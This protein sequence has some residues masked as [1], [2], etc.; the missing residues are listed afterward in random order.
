MIRRALVLVKERR[1]KKRRESRMFK[2]IQRIKAWESTVRRTHQKHQPSARRRSLVLP[3]VSASPT[4]ADVDDADDLDDATL[5]HAERLLP[6]GDF[7]TG[8]WHNNLPHGTGKYLWTDGCMYEGEWRHGKTMGKGKFSWPSGATYEGEF[9]SGFMDGFGTYTGS[10]GDTYRGS[11]SMNLKH[12]QGKKSYANGDYYDGEWRSGL[13]DGHGRY[14]WKNGNEYVGEWRAGV[15]HGRGTLVWVNGNRYDGGWEDGFPKGNGSFR[16]AD[17]SLYVGYWSEE[18]DGIQQKGVYYPSPAATSPTARD[19]HAAFAADLGDCKVCPGETVSILPSQKTPNWLGMEENF[20][21]KQA[22]WRQSKSNDGRPRR[23]A[24]ADTAG[25]GETPKRT[26]GHNN[27][28][29]GAAGS[30]EADGDYNC[31]AEEGSVARGRGASSDGANDFMGGLSLEETE[32]T[33]TGRWLPIKWPPP[34]VKKQGETISKG[35]KNY[36]LMLNLQ[37]GIRVLSFGEDL[38]VGVEVTAM[39]CSHEFHRTCLGKWLEKSHL[40]PL[41]RFPMPTVGSR[42]PHRATGVGQ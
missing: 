33:G 34:E 3:P 4:A 39:P 17:G 20:L 28:I 23:R 18:N 19:P 36:D 14:T 42:V 1:G 32:S 6:N 11:W 24:S 7:Y 27:S 29:I 31:D 37:L 10:L 22:V 38:E 21:Q 25:T 8:Q 30:W 13:Q 2:D 5:H 40:C 9:K 41:C 26:N 35:P 12:G 15:I 16:W